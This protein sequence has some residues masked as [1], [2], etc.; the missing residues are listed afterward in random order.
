[1]NRSLF[2]FKP[3]S[4]KLARLISIKSPSSFRKSIGRVRNL[5][6]LSKTHKIRGL[7]LAKNRAKAQLGRKNLSLKKRNEF[8][9]IA[10]TKISL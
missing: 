3:K 8:R 1:M 5:K 6:G 7:T 2:G 10:R 9:I 4:A